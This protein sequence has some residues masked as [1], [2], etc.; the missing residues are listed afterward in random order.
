MIEECGIAKDAA[1]IDIGGGASPLCK[2]LLDNGYTNLSVL[3]ISAR[4]LALARELLGEDRQRVEWLHL[5]ITR[6]PLPRGYALWHDRAVFHFLVDPADRQAYA[7]SMAA[8]LDAGAHAIIAAFA[9][10][11]PRQCSGLEIV[12]YDAARLCSALGDRFVLID[13]QQEQHETP[14]GV[15]QAFGYDRFCRSSQGRKSTVSEY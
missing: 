12:R 10:D 2:C 13:Q 15:S 9:L 4:A 3:D 5:D 8:A 1:I 11:G 14:A 7:D 6:Q